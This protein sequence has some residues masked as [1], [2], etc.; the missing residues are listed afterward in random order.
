VTE[1]LLEF[2][3]TV[4]DKDGR[5]HVAVVLGEER[6][7]GRWIGRIRFVPTAGEGVL[8]T[9][10]ETT[11]PDRDDLKY[12]ASGLTYFYL[13]GA[14]ERARRRGEAGSPGGR[15]VATEPAAAQPGALA[16]PG[17]PPPVYVPRLEVASMDPGIVE[18]VL[19]A[20]DPRPG[21]GREV[22]NA[23]FIVYE[24]TGGV[25]GASHVFAVQFGSPNA[26]ATLANWLW[27]RLHGVGVEVRVNGRVVELTNDALKRAIVG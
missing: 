25:D 13:E 27:S 6:E 19:G 3:N 10:R 16:A 14:L 8:E 11:Q 21:T 18:E 17:S 2:E 20:R 12:W 4:E 7:D 15:S 22:P 9:D 26:G 24:G 23:G 5:S 1:E